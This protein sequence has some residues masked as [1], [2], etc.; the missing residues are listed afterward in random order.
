MRATI[1]QYMTRLINSEDVNEM[2]TIQ[3]KLVGL[4]D[5][6]NFAMDEDKAIQMKRL[7]TSTI[8]NYVDTSDVT[9]KSALEEHYNTLNL[10]LV[11]KP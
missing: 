9:L 6:A 7:I 5:D 11:T 4:I 8:K 10:F 2:K 1:L 3:E